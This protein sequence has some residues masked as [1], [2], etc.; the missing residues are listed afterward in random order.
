MDDALLKFVIV[1]GQS[2]NLLSDASFIDFMECFRKLAVGKCKRQVQK[3]CQRFLPSRNPL[4]KRI[5]AKLD[6]V[7][8]DVVAKIGPAKENRRRTDLG[9]CEKDVDYLAP[10]TSHFFRY[11]QDFVL[12]FTPLLPGVKKT[13]QYVQHSKLEQLDIERNDFSK[14]F[15]DNRTKGPMLALSR[16]ESSALF[17]AIWFY[18]RKAL[19]LGLTKIRVWTSVHKK[20]ALK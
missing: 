10:T 16:E 8:V 4:S 1:T 13:S 6:L 15:C 5:G 2:M 11:K 9:L 12:V 18:Y 14:F 20:L 3:D 17:Y 7:K 19:L